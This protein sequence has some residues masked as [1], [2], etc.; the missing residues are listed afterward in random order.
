[1]TYTNADT[2][3][4]IVWTNSFCSQLVVVLIY[5]LVLHDWE[6]GTVNFIDLHVHVFLFL[7]IYTEFMITR[8]SMTGM[9]MLYVVALA[10]LYTYTLQ[11]S[12][13][14]PL[15]ATLSLTHT[16]LTL[17]PPSPCSLSLLQHYQWHCYGRQG[18]PC[19]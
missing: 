2:N 18:Q 10:L 1:M 15:C 7:I 17:P 11:G 6:T 4:T 14:H 13:L 16:R 5:W 9:H 12:Q 3:T 19:V 8:F